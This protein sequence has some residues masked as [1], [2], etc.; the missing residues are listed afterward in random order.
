MPIGPCDKLATQSGADLPSAIVSPPR[1]PE[2]EEAVKKKTKRL[3]IVAWVSNDCREHFLSA[4]KTKKRKDKLRFSL[5]FT[6]AS[7]AF[8]LI[9]RTHST[10]IA[11]GLKTASIFKCGC[12]VVLRCAFHVVSGAE[13]AVF[14]K[15]FSKIMLRSTQL[16]QSFP[17]TSDSLSTAAM[18]AER[19]QMLHAAVYFGD[20]APKSGREPLLWCCLQTHT[21]GWTMKSSDCY[22]WTRCP[23]RWN[24]NVLMY[25]TQSEKLVP[26]RWPLQGWILTVSLKDTG[27]VLKAA[28][29]SF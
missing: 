23:T 28:L 7:S 6:S 19:R 24:L 4:F 3:N 22:H 2:H 21:V 16:K 27:F 26:T 9:R 10:K 14:R 29:G 17:N 13:A 15:T 11:A 1:D 5:T 20:I 8:W 12:Q 18:S 25:A